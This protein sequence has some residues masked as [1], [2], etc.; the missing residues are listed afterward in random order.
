MQR[1]KNLQ[2]FILGFLNYRVLRIEFNSTCIEV[3]IN[4]S[5]IKL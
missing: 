2:N 4:L 3:K 5:L 1:I